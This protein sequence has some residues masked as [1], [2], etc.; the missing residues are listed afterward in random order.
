LDCT[1][2]VWGL[3]RAPG[4]GECCTRSIPMGAGRGDSSIISFQTD[5]LTFNYANKD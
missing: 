1:I 5:N 3:P 4:T 2:P